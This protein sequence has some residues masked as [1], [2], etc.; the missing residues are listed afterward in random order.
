MVTCRHNKMQIPD[1]SQPTLTLWPTPPDISHVVR[2]ME[3]INLIVRPTQTMFMRRMYSCHSLVKSTL[4]GK[5]R[6]Y[7]ISQQN[8]LVASFIPLATSTVS[9]TVLNQ[10]WRLKCK[11]AFSI[12]IRGFQNGCLP[13][14]NNDNWEAHFKK[15]ERQS[16]AASTQQT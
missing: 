1:E 16:K 6:R 10:A 8:S 12:T 2:A 7:W 4:F 14:G 15:I 13:N 9:S 11:T 5:T 3:I